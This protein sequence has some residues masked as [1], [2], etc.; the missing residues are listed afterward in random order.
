MREKTFKYHEHLFF[1]IKQYKSRTLKHRGYSI[2]NGI[3]KG[4]RHG[5]G[6]AINRE[7]KKMANKGQILPNTSKHKIFKDFEKGRRPAELWGKKY[8]Y[9]KYRTLMNYFYEWKKQEKERRLNANPLYAT[10]V[11]I[12]DHIKSSSKAKTNPKPAAKPSNKS[13]PV[14][15]SN[16]AKKE[17]ISSSSSVGTQTPPT[18]IKREDNAPENPV[19]PL[20]KQICNPFRD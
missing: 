8:R 17:P 11:L 16:D 12:R 14:R 13:E 20:R 9:L 7:Y 15:I 19:S 10:G 5:Y 1:L 3:E 2:G 4:I 18:A 6:P